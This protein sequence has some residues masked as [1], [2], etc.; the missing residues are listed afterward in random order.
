MR[1]AGPRQAQ[2]ARAGD[3]V[4]GID[5]DSGTTVSL[6]PEHW[7]DTW[8][9]AL[10]AAYAMND[11]VTL[12]AGVALDETPVPDETRTPRLPD[13][14]RTSVAVG[15]RWQPSRSML[16]DFGCAQLVYQF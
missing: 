1:D 8:H 15:A 13:T 9:Y 12:R 10:G 2:L 3:S 14:D 4:A 16:L 5:C 6:T 7:K 11:V